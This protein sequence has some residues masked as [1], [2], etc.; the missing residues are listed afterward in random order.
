LHPSAQ[1]EFGAVIQ[2]VAAEFKIQVIVATRSPFML[3]QGQPVANVLLERKVERRKL[4]ETCLVETSHTNWM[5]PF[6]LALGVDN[7]DLKPWYD[8]FF[9]ANDSVLIVEGDT[10]KEY[11]E[12]LK[13][14]KHGKNSLKLQGQIFAYNG[15][16]SLSNTALIK[17]VKSRHRN[18]VVTY[19][20]DREEYVLKMLGRAG[21]EKNRNAF[22]VGQN[23][24]GKRTIEGLL[25]DSVLNDVHSE[26][27]QLVQQATNDT[28]D[29]RKSAQSRLKQLYLESFKAEAAKGNSVFGGF[30]PLVQKI[31]RAL[32]GESNDPDS[33]TEP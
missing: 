25:P 22:A 8:L 15:V 12:L 10:D 23:A 24:P 7:G 13:D 30:Y 17:Y 16:D 21:I 19:D 28:G 33:K 14:P 20:L 27:T 3:S 1:A 31:N 11:F 29:A 9:S 26:H 32:E 4:R 5:K 18:T 6:G 2:K